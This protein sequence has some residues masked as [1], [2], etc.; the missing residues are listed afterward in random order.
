MS[1]YTH[2]H[3]HR[4]TFTYA[5]MLTGVDA[6]KYRSRHAGSISPCR[7]SL[8][9][10]TAPWPCL[11]I[12]LALLPYPLILGLG[13][14][15]TGNSDPGQAKAR[16]CGLD[17]KPYLL[18]AMTDPNTDPARRLHIAPDFCSR[19]HCGILDALADATCESSSIEPHRGILPGVLFHTVWKATQFPCSKPA[20]GSRLF[21]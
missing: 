10:G 7:L 9:L 15:E 11:T 6:C 19:Y 14:Q 5:Y 17:L 18:E 13:N 3:T 1:V 21:H 20:C 12:L 2:K 8:L 4:H 16:F